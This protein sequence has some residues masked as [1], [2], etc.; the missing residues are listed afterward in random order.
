MDVWRAGHG[1]TDELNLLGLVLSAVLLAM[2]CV[3]ADRV[4]AWRTSVNPSA[5]APP[6][7][8]FV[9]ARL[10]FLSLAGIGVYMTVHSSVSPTTSPG[11]TTN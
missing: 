3:K 4:R 7:S 1:R 8:A 5:P 6:D 11:A 2:A 10:I 9:V